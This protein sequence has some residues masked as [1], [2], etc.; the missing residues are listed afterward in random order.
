MTTKKATTKK[1]I[2]KAAT[3]AATTTKSTTT[4]KSLLSSEKKRTV[5]IVGSGNWGST[6]AKIIG[7]NIMSGEAK[8][9]FEQEVRMWV[10]DEDIKQDDGSVRKLS[11]IINTDHENVK[12]LKGHKLPEIVK[13]V[14]D[15]KDAVKGATVLVWVLPHQ[16]IPKSAMGVKD[17]V[18]KDAVSIS[19]V[20]GGVDIKADGLKL[21]SE[22]IS[23]IMGHDVSVI[24]G[25]NVA[26]E[27]ARG[28]FCEATIGATDQPT[29]ELFHKLF[30]MKTFSVNVVDEVASVELCGALKN[31]VALAAGFVDGIGMGGNTKAAVVRIGLK[32][33]QKF[34]SHF[35][36]ETKTEVFSESCGVAD[37][38]TTCF[39]GRNRKC[40]E[41]FAES[42]VRGEPRSW[43]EIETT[44]LN[45]QKIQG[46]LTAQEI[47]PLIQHH[48]LE[49]E[50]PLMC[51]TYN[52]AFKDASPKTLCDCL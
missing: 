27:V 29:G 33:M 46:T 30:D 36:P 47:M 5:C 19:L 44:M 17:V 50:L 13:A 42:R 22:T 31:V 23:E 52:I 39:G 12:Y 32:E 10:F 9:Y 18:E 1:T 8:N 40:A 24:M 45:G 35:Y 20:K 43:D 2:A 14:P 25:A 4:K 15:I 3:K 6:A 26:D 28:D 51:A 48:R 49:S 21:C 7:E 16:F 38:I 11:E 34:I 41:A 37:L